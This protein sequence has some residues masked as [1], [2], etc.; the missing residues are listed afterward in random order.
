MNERAARSLI[1]L[2]ALLVIVLA[3]SLGL[4]QMQRAAYKQNL[5]A[6]QQQALNGAA[7][8]LPTDWAAADVGA[9]I[10]RR[11]SLSGRWLE[12][13]TVFLDNRTH[14]GRAGFHVLTPMQSAPDRPHLLVL[15]GWVAQDSHDRNRLPE[16]PSPLEPVHVEGIAE[17]NLPAAL[18]LQRAP[19]SGRIWQ[20][21]ELDD[22]ARWSGLS[23]LPMIVRQTSAADDGL[24]R[25]WPRP[26][27]DVDRHHGYAV[28]WFAMAV[29]AAGA[30]AWWW[31]SLSRGARS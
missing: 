8:A 2:G 10:G 26:G 23:L 9:L 20:A 1:S 21:V 15:R 27:R 14:Q 31:R 17:A 4:W 19:P 13:K 30:W 24:V 11:I 5:A 18:Q 25:D 12:Q 3:A 7:L 22:Y 29:A 16:L 28:Q 6:Q